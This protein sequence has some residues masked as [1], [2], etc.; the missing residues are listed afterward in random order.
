MSSFPQ[1]TDRISSTAERKLRTRG[2]D[3]QGRK[4]SLL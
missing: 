1:M 4:I 3:D 2:E